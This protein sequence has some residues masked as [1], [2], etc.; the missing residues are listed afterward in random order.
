MKIVADIPTYPYDDELKD[1]IENRVV[2]FLDKMYR[3]KMHLF[4]DRV[5]IFSGETSIYHIPTIQTRNGIDYESVRIRKPREKEDEIHLI[6][7]AEVAKWHGY[8]RM[9]RGLGEYYKGGGERK[10][11]MHLVG[12]GPMLGEYKQI[13]EQYGI[14]EY[15]IFH[16]RKF[17]EKLDEIYDGCDIGIEGLAAFRKKIYVSSSLKSREYMDLSLIW[18]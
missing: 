14:K 1:G 11:I 2:L 17:G 5:V 9:Y 6:A 4:V 18:M 13:V 3:D 8:E 15:C 7:V 10:V 12:D 16:G